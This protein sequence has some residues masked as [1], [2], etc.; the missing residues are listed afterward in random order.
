MGQIPA[1]GNDAVENEIAHKQK[2]LG[3]H[4]RNLKYLQLQAEQQKTKVPQKLRRDIAAERQKIADTEKA[5][6]V[7]RVTQNTSA[8]WQALLIDTSDHWRDIIKINL[9]KL[10]GEI[11]EGQID[12]A[13]EENEAVEDSRVAIIVLSAGIQ[14]EPIATQWIEAIAKWGKSFPIILFSGAD[15]VEFVA[16]LNQALFCQEPPVDIT[17]IAKE[18]FDPDWFVRLVKHA[19][20]SK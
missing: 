15:D 9:D 11:V 14:Q 20:F 12:F 2:L 8:T 4:R 17:T 1:D 13:S 16:R 10:G 18:T 3:L 7:A 5:I 19:L 6:I